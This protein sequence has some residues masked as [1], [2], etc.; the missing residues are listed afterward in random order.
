MPTY[1]ACPPKV[2]VVWQVPRVMTNLLCVVHKLL[3]C[4][5][6]RL[7]PA[8]HEAEHVSFGELRLERNQLGGSAIHIFRQR[9]L[10]AHTTPHHTTPHHTTPHHT[11]PHHTTPHHTTPHHTTP[12]HT[13]RVRL[14]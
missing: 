8:G 12:H 11:T 6:Q 2:A 10:E 9:N 13:R 5:Q 3:L 4:L 14:S 1:A 7:G